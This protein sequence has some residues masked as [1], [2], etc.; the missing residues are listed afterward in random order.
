[1]GGTYFQSF[2]NPQIF[3]KELIAIGKGGNEQIKDGGKR[4]FNF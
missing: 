3:D 2:A 4:V 1:M